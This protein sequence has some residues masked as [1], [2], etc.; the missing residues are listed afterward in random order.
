MAGGGVT[1]GG[2]YDVPGGA[3]GTGGQVTVGTSLSCQDW[4]DGEDVVVR[5]EVESAGRRASTTAPLDLGPGSPVHAQLAEV[6]GE[7]AQAHPLRVDAVSAVLDP[8]RPT[9]ALEWTVH[10]PTARVLVVGE[11]SG[12][13]DLR[14][15]GPDVMP[16][17]AL[18]PVTIVPGATARVRTTLEV[19]TCQ[20]ASFDPAG[21]EVS[22]SVR[23]PGTG[24]DVE[25]MTLPMPRAERATAFAAA[26]RAC[27]GAP[28]VLSPQVSVTM[29]AAPGTPPG[30]P[31]SV[32][33]T[34]SAQVAADGRWTAAFGRPDWY[35]GSDAAAPFRDGDAAVDAPGDL[36]LVGQWSAPGCTELSPLLGDGVRV[37]LVLSAARDYPYALQVGLRS[38]TSGCAHA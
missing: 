34:V 21:A 14:D 15:P 32:V 29:R 30:R 9:V 27:R 1:A 7:Y 5:L 6:C 10:N 35:A 22:L 23:E 20:S 8:T 11:G 17:P 38:D 37:P 28:L 31:R 2:T 24:D 12:M 13:T 36:L 16:G 3:A 4:A 18:R 26:A 33:L 25:A 19:T